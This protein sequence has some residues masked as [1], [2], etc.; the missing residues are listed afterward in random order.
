MVRSR[1]YHGCSMSDFSKLHKL[2]L[3]IGRQEGYNDSAGRILS[4]QAPA[5]RNN[6]GS[7]RASSFALRTENGY[8]IF[9]NPETGW[10][11][12]ERQLLLYRNRD[13]LTIEQAIYKWAPP[14]DNNRT[15]AYLA[16]VLADTGFRST[17]KLS[18]LFPYANPDAP[19]D[20]AGLPG[21]AVAGFSLPSLPSLSVSTDLTFIPWF[22]IVLGL[23]AASLLYLTRS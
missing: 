14:S 13:G 21:V 17:D 5:R 20:V 2:A 22:E 7:L 4:S 15:A 11:A 18:D 9:V 1:V 6:P 23:G 3:A 16:G 19:P 8:S 10:R 12:L